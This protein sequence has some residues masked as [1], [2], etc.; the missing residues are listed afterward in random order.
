MTYILS[1][2]IGY[3]F[4]CFSFAKII[5]K[6]KGIDIKK[7]G[8]NNAGA[9]NVYISVGKIYGVFA[10]LG[11]ILKSFIACWVVFG[12]FNQNLSLSVFAGIMAVIGHIYPFWM[13]F[14]G[15]KGLASLMG[16]ILFIG[17][18]D[19]AVF[20]I[21]IAAITLATDYIALGTLA[22][23]SIMPFYSAFILKD[24]VL[25]VTVFAVLAVIIWYKH[26]ENIVRIKN[27][28][29]IGFLRKNKTKKEP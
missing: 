20:A 1:A 19:F 6:M 21:I 18:D 13:K 16:I 11:D 15:G 26:R 7:V 12:L 5:A 22:A 24:S 23:A 28:T 9:S 17:F 8:T 4:G 2:A 3:F 29:E 10:A 27:G 25:T 14:N